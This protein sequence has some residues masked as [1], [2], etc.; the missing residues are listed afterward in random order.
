MPR[1]KVLTVAAAWLG[2]MLFAATPYAKSDPL[3]TACPFDMAPEHRQSCVLGYAAMYQPGHTA[4]NC[5]EL[6]ERESVMYG[7]GSTPL[8]QSDYLAACEAAKRELIG[9]NQ[10]AF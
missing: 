4:A 9:M 6:W 10:R 3:T 1:L 7:R 8:N 2:I 5:Q